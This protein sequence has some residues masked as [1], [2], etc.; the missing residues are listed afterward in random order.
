VVGGKILAMSTHHQA[1]HGEISELPPGVK[2]LTP[3]GVL[4]WYGI[5][6]G[7]LCLFRW[8]PD[9]P[10]HPTPVL[11]EGRIFRVP[12]PFSLQ[13]PEEPRSFRLESSGSMA[14]AEMLLV[15]SGGW[16]KPAVLHHT[17]WAGGEAVR[18]RAGC[19]RP[20]QAGLQPLAQLC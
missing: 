13:E 7:K 2:L 15:Q 10:E 16:D 12:C 4:C 5:G 9:Q 1:F 11:L 14:R 20:A 6:A 8:G 19:C 18:S 17:P 3:G